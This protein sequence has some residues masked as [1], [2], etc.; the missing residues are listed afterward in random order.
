MLP[1]WLTA[2]KPVTVK[3]EPKEF[4]VPFNDATETGKKKEEVEGIE[5]SFL[6]T[7]GRTHLTAS[8]ISLPS[9]LM[10]PLVCSVT[11]PL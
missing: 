3:A 7:L 4:A 1:S 8:L 2:L 10:L 5:R 11:K 6:N 9:D